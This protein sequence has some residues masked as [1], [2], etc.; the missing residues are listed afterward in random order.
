MSILNIEMKNNQY[1]YHSFK[2]TKWLLTVSLLFSIFAFTGYAGN[3]Q[4]VQQQSTQ[5]VLVISNDQP[6]C[7]CIILYQKEFVFSG[8]NES[9]NC[10][11]KNW[12]NTLIVY[13]VLTKVKLDNISKQFY[14]NDPACCLLQVKTIPQ[15]FS[16]NVLITLIV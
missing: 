3:Y 6:A 16:E 7:S 2:L 9:L 13:N 12:T 15:S 8:A 1:T 10:L 11:R 5:I 14:A 4:L